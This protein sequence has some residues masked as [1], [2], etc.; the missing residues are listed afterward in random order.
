M[1]LML[2]RHSSLLCAVLVLFPVATP[3][4]AQNL[5]NTCLGEARS[6]C[7]STITES[8]SS[9]GRWPWAEMLA[10]GLLSGIISPLLQAALQHRVVWKRRRI[11]ETRLKAF[12]DATQA[13]AMSAT[14]AL[15]PAL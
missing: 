6:V 2:R 14:D 11:I 5:A 9:R 1:I 13:P 15:D 8:S 3:T 10:A 12:S 4:Q 7:P